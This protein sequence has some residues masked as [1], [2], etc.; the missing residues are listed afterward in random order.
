MF[1]SEVKAVQDSPTDDIN[2]TFKHRQN[3]FG[4]ILSDSHS[5]NGASSCRQE[6]RSNEKEF[7]KCQSVIQTIHQC[8]HLN[9]MLVKCL[10][11][12]LQ[13]TTE[14]FQ[15][16]TYIESPSGEFPS[17]PHAEVNRARHE[18]TFKGT[19]KDHLTIFLMKGML[20]MGSACGERRFQ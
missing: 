13:S 10:C 6:L 7:R 1:T 3:R 20:D 9:S 4:H 5:L 16:Q 18:N 15:L 17:F 12:C 8:L 14:L 2:L 19:F 11:D